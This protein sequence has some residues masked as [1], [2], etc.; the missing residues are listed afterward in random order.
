[1]KWNDQRAMSIEHTAMLSNNN[2]EWKVIS[3]SS[4]DAIAWTLIGLLSSIY[5]FYIWIFIFYLKSHYLLSEY[6]YYYHLHGS[7]ISSDGVSIHWMLAYVYRKHYSGCYLNTENGKRPHSEE[8][9]KWEIFLFLSDLGNDYAGDRKQFI[10][11]M[12]SLVGDAVVFLIE[13]I[14]NHFIHVPVISGHLISKYSARRS[15]S[16]S[17]PYESM[18]PSSVWAP[19]PFWH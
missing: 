18:A 8:G 11:I 1:M 3:P 6:Y 14:L 17:F 12:N 9:N 16:R 4:F 15:V 10:I 13:V 2:N 7:I 19:F 5:S